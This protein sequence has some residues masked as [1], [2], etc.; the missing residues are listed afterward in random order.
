MI[1][2]RQDDKQNEET[3]VKDIEV[4]S[5]LDVKDINM[6]TDE[7]TECEGD[8]IVQLASSSYNEWLADQGLLMLSESEER[9]DLQMKVE[10]ISYANEEENE[11]EH[12]S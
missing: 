11:T 1:T 8:A 5:E 9:Y 2:K 7:K 6:H 4:G 3:D 12:V 10:D